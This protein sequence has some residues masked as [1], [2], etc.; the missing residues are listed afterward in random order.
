MK[1][2]IFSSKPYDKEYFVRLNQEYQFNFTFFESALNESTANLCIGYE[3]VCAFVNDN[4]D[5]A[6][7]PMLAENRV[8]MIAMRCA[9]FN[10]VDI[11]SAVQY[12]VKVVRV[13]AYS[14]EAIAEHSI[15]LIL[16]LNRKTH[17]AYNRVRE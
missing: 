14:P 2:A 7:I 1:V 13:P 10:N 4:L 3:V 16:T 9:G 12:G 15:A 5:S 17:K 6:V 8:K 11:K